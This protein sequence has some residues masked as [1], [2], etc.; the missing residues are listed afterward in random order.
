MRIAVLALLISCLAFGQANTLTKAEVAD[1]WILLFDGESLF[2]WTEEG[3]AK[4]RIED[5]VLVGDAPEAGWLRS[6]SA[7]SDFILKLEFRTGVEGN[8]GVFLRSANAPA[9]HE[10]GYELQIWNQHPEFATGSLVNHAAAKKT[11][12]KPD[13]WNSYVVRVEGDR[14]IVNLNGEQILDARDSK[15]LVG[16]IGLQYNASKKVEFRNMKLKPLGLQPVSNSADLSA[17]RKVERPAGTDEPPVWSVKD[18]AIHVEKGPGQ[19]ETIQKWSDFVLQI[20]VRTNPVDANH[21]PNS[22]V[23]VRGTPGVFW[24]GYESQIRNEY[25][26][27][28]RTKPV[29]FGTGGIYRNQ[30]AR[31][32]VVNDGEYF[33]MT[34][35]AR[36][37][38]LA[39]W[40][41]GY[42]VS[43]FEDKNPAGES[44]RDKQA[45][46]GAGVIS[47]QA[48]DPTT[49]L[50][51]RN[52]RVAELPEK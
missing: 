40:V 23:F 28:D 4:W 41:N 51:F 26:D 2:G 39:V 20:D 10:T 43:D 48:H 36:G 15:S 46:I 6:N 30:P 14:W 47:L 1:G 35:V 9:P 17:W 27:G 45:V 11:G 22:G 50:D 5:G 42:P 24:S 8:S 25:E 38:H 7:F 34:T 49:N 16:H 44:V 19:L 21:H 3:G 33:T 18:G 13:E 52:L 37:R 12:H 32:V 31:K 29:D